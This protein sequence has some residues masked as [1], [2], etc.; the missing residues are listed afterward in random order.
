[1]ADCTEK[2]QNTSKGL[3]I[4]HLLYA[5]I[6]HRT[7]GQCVDGRCEWARRKTM[8]LCGIYAVR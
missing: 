4:S 6:G 7:M 5:M 2:R 1:M 8:N 3:L